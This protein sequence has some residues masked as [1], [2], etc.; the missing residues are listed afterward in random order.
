MI[1]IIMYDK[2]VSVF[3]ELG[4]ANILYFLGLFESDNAY[5]KEFIHQC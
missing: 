1:T 5:Y 2:S 3:K 4:R